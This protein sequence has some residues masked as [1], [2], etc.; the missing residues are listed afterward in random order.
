MNTY[1]MVSIETKRVVDTFCNK[2]GKQM[3]SPYG[4]EGSSFT[5]EFNYGS[6]MDGL[7]EFFHLCDNCFNLMV[8]E[9]RFE[10]EKY[11]DDDEE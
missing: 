3:N 2:C 7:I 4:V 9:F 6:K 8:S 1:K 5:A 10:T 11:E